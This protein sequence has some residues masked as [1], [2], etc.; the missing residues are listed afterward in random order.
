MFDPVEAYELPTPK[1]K[2][3]EALFNKKLSYC[4]GTSWDI[5]YPPAVR[6]FEERASQCGPF[7]CF[8]AEASIKGWSLLAMPDVDVYRTHIAA[9]LFGNCKPSFK[10]RAGP[11]SAKCDFCKKL[12]PKTKLQEITVR[13]YKFSVCA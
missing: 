5:S 1:K 12:S 2:V 7:I 6:S 11:A 3:L 9:T 10:P 8:Y 13:G 4:C